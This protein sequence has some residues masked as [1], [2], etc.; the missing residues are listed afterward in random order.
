[1]NS[2]VAIKSLQEGNFAE[3]A[4]QKPPCHVESEI[5]K[6]KNVTFR[7]LYVVDIQTKKCNFNSY[8]YNV[9]EVIKETPQINE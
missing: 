9:N 3:E 6:H 1:M 5:V 4:Q 8:I 7:V 2:Y